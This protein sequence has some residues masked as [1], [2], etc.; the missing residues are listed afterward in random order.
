MRGRGLG[1]WRDTR[2]RRDNMGKGGQDAV[3]AK[4]MW[5]RGTKDAREAYLED[6]DTITTWGF[7]SCEITLDAAGWN[8]TPPLVWSGS[9]MNGGERRVETGNN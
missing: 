2:G 5:D 3:E 9:A 8:L 1:I 4:S 6:A 7:V